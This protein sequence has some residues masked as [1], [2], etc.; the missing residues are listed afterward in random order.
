MAI[1][2]PVVPQQE[3]NGM[4]RRYFVVLCREA[5]KF[6]WQFVIENRVPAFIC[7]LLGPGLGAWLQWQFGA[8]S[9]DDMIRALMGGAWGLLATLALFA[10]VFLAHCFYV[11]PKRRLAAAAVKIRELE[12][13]LDALKQVHQ[14][15]LIIALEELD[16][17]HAEGSGMAVLYQCPGAKLP[18]QAEAYAWNDRAIEFAKREIFAKHI[19]THDWA[20]FKR[21]WNFADC[22]RI[23]RVLHE[24]RYLDDVNDVKAGRLKYLWGRVK[25]LEELIAKIKGLPADEDKTPIE[26]LTD[27]AS[28]VNSL[29][30][31]YANLARTL[32]HAEQNDLLTRI[33][34]FLRKTAPEYVPH[35]NEIIEKPPSRVPDFPEDFTEDDKQEWSRTRSEPCDRLFAVK[36]YL[37]RIISDLRST[38]PS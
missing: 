32:P 37:T 10:A 28:E 5:L 26:F 8:Q 6:A 14:N 38:L 29:L 34:S 27:F 30:G 36:A 16:A 31:V 24:S 4:S 19:S 33:R 11:I 23:A 22:Q 9:K 12:A 17:I 21:D 35:L 15:P 3:R 1:L 18:T 13:E 7:A 25:R 20:E 2:P